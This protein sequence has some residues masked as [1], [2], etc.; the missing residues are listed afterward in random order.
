MTKI[1]DKLGKTNDCYIWFDTEYSD[2][3]LEKAWLLQVSALITD[4]SL[5][6]ILSPAHDIKLSIR[7]PADKQPSQWV[8]QNLPELV[9]ICRSPEAINVNDAD[10]LLA[11]YVDMAVD[12]LSPHKGQRP[13]L[14]GNSIH[15]DWRL[16]QRFLPRFLIRLHY[17][18]LDVTAIKIE[19][20]RLHPGSEFDKENPATIQKYFPEAV[21]PVSGNRHDAYYD[22]QASIAE[23]AFYRSRLFRHR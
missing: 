15:S 1:K 13:I 14:A 5:R 3:E 6:R 18:H 19:W 16:V 7:L 20:T 11:A 4:A 21:L 8:E 12:R 23:L 22:L 10:E 17:R 9:K 2:L